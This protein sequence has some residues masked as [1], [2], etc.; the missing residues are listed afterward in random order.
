VTT[1]PIIPDRIYRKYEG[2]R[3]FGYSKSRLDVL[4]KQGVI[5]PTF[6]LTPHGRA[7]GWFGHQILDHHARVAAEIAARQAAE[8]EAV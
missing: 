4:E 8:A 3:L 2:P 5:P 6:K 1:E 7:R